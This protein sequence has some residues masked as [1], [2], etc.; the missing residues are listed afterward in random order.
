MQDVR[1]QRR[2][3][4]AEVHCDGR[5][6]TDDHHRQEHDRRVADVTQPLGQVHEDLADG[7]RCRHEPGPLQLTVAHQPQADDDRDKARRVDREGGRDAERADRQP[8][9]GRPDHARAVEHR[10]VECDR[11]PDV[12]RPD[13]LVGE[14]LADGH[15]DRIGT[16]EQHGQQ[17]DHPD[18]HEA[19]GRQDRE[20]RR[21]DH[22]H[23]LDRE[24]RLA[25]G[26]DVGE[27]AREQ[28]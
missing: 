9:D 5:D 3:Q 12:A 16:T 13:H 11:V 1:R 2:D 19:G 14:R 28:A 26:Q 20:D 27:D 24:Q 15:V 23:D 21:E 4:D 7:T 25:L 18:L 22:H 17:H 8:G 6:E 10:G